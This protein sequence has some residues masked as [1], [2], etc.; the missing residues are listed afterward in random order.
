MS[1]SFKINSERSLGKASSF[2]K[3]FGILKDFPYLTLYMENIFWA[4][5]GIGYLKK[6]YK[7]RFECNWA[8]LWNLKLQEILDTMSILDTVK[9]VA[10]NIFL[11]YLKKNL[12]YYE[13]I[14]WTHF[15]NFIDNRNLRSL[16]ETRTIMRNYPC[17]G[18][19]W[20]IF[21]QSERNFYFGRT[22]AIWEKLKLLRET[23]FETFVNFYGKLKLKK[24][25]LR[26]FEISKELDL[27]STNW[28][29]FIYMFSDHKPIVA[30]LP[31]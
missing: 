14:L 8:I 5:S 21:E 2:T 31:L 9:Q 16:G 15:S 20:T 23:T 13:K 7:K 3:I 25:N 29:I 27:S 30:F 24:K 6:V 4:Y 28:D 11:E 10:E 26:E 18:C 1:I 12:K 17:F 19:T 22:W